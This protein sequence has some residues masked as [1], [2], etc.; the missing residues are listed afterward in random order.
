M[1][2]FMILGLIKLRLIE[3]QC[4][5]VDVISTKHRIKNF[6]VQFLAVANGMQRITIG[7]LTIFIHVEDG[8]CLDYGDG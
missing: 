5:E 4:A 7:T 6:N 1:H 3:L 2:V 8:F